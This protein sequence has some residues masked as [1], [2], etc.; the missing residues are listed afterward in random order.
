MGIGD[1][2]VACVA[3]IAWCT[4]R[5]MC[6]L[7]LFAGD[8]GVISASLALSPSALAAVPI[9]IAIAETG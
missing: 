2:F 7:I 9:V 3:L 8:A 5:T 4:L 6:V 1:L